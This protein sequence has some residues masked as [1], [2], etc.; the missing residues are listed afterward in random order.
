MITCTSRSAFISSQHCFC[1]EKD[2]AS[3]TKPVV[4]FPSYSDSNLLVMNVDP[5]PFSATTVLSQVVLSPPYLV[6]FCRCSTEQTGIFS[7]KT[8]N[9]SGLYFLKRKITE[10]IFEHLIN[11]S[12]SINRNVWRNNH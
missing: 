9:M 2:L 6:V 10:V 3:K 5:V 11:T 12:C 4:F 8:K 1:Q 7:Q